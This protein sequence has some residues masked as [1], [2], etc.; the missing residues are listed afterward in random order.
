MDSSFY[1][2]TFGI[3]T[4]ALLCYALILILRPFAGPLLWAA[5]IAFMLYPLHVQLTPRAARSSGTP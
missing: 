4:A 3:V 1:G 5:C 2:R